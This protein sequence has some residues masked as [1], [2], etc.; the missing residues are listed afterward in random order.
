MKVAPRLDAPPTD[1]G[2]LQRGDLAAYAAETLMRRK[3]MMS[4]AAIHYALVARHAIMVS[5]RCTL[6]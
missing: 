2:K 1:L 4:D 5:P 3:L 6:I